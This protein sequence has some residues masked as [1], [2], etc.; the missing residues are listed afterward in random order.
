MGNAPWPNSVFRSK[1]VLSDLGSRLR[2]AQLLFGRLLLDCRVLMLGELI[3]GDTLVRFERLAL[4]LCLRS[5]LRVGVLQE[6][7]LELLAAVR[8]YDSL[9]G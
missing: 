7:L 1:L 3:D 5:T 6:F 8:V 4:V 2:S 9:E